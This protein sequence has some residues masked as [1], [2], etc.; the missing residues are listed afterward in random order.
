M[1]YEVITI[2]KGL[3][4]EALEILL[5]DAKLFLTN[6]A[7]RSVALSEPR[8]YMFEAFFEDASLLLSGLRPEDVAPSSKVG[9]RPQLVDV[10]SGR[11][12][13]DFRNNFV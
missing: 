12:V 4:F 1:L 10:E 5:R 3:D 8:K 13:M 2:L 9:I 7:F 11:L 6:N